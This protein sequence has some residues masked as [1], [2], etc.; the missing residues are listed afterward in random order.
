MLALWTRS[1]PRMI[2]PRIEVAPEP[3]NGRPDLPTRVEDYLRAHHVLSL[4]TVGHP[5]GELAEELLPHAAT[6]F[7]AADRSLRLICL[8]REGSQ[9][10]EHLRGSSAVA[11]TVTGSHED[12]KEIQGIQFWGKAV[13]LEG[14]ERVIALAVYVSRFPF[15]KDLLSTWKTRGEMRDLAVF[16]IRLQRVALTDNT[17]GVFGREVLDLD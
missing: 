4:A 12:W 7:Y 14:G 8:S 11:G 15:V 2:R 13:V 3:E 5:P 16:R 10:V 17:T 1:L 6:V 9:H